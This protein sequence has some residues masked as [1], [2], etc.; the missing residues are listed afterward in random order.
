MFTKFF[1]V[2]LLIHLQQDA[3]LHNLFISGELL[4]IFWVL[5]P[6]IIRSINNCV[7]SI[8]YLSKRYCY[9]PLLW[10]SWNWFGC[11]VGILLYCKVFYL[12][13]V[14]LQPHQNRSIQFPHHTQT[15]SKS[16]TIA[17]GSSNGLTSTRYVN[18]VVYAPDDGWRYHPKYV[19]QFSRNK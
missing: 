5:S 7:Y 17:A 8:W 15:S 2:I 19:E 12:I 4:Y 9:L 11:G 1:Y 3:T 10:K 13:L 18:T 16:S 14:W 6:T